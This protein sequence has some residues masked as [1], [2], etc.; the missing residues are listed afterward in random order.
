M[1][2]DRGRP[3]VPTIIVPGA[4]AV[5]GYVGIRLLTSVWGGGESEFTMMK[6]YGFSHY[7]IS[8]IDYWPLIA[9][10][11]LGAGWVFCTHVGPA[12]AAVGCSGTDQEHFVGRGKTRR[13]GQAARDARRH[14]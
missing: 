2:V 6:F 11:A 5:A 7:L 10:S 8:Y 13:P 3:V 12:L 1:W 9:S 4:S 14:S